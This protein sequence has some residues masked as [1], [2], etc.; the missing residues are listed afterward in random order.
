MIM[1]N[2]DQFIIA[3]ESNIIDTANES[4]GLIGLGLFAW[5]IGISAVKIQNKRDI[6]KVKTDRNKYFANLNIDPNDSKVVDEYIDK[7]KSDVRKDIMD[8]LN[9]CKTDSKF[10]SELDKKFESTKDRLIKNRDEFGYNESEINTLKNMKKE[11]YQLHPTVDSDGE[12]IYFMKE[13]KTRAFYP[14]ALYIDLSWQLYSDVAS[15]LVK[16]LV[17][18]Y[19]EQISGSLI[20]ISLTDADDTPVGISIW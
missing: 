19:S 5:V 1:D 20:S 2:I 16:A 18:K 14:E 17:V 10:N 11:V 6:K 4:L 3:C 9:K 15:N 7:L 8:S 12:R 13:F